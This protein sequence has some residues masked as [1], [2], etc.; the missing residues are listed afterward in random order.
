MSRRA[1]GLLAVALLSG[2]AWAQQRAIDTTTYRQELGRIRAALD[3][4]DLEG[5]KTRAA[6]LRG[7]VVAD[8]SLRYESDGSLLG[9]LRRAADA[10]AASALRPRLE[11][12]I[13]SLDQPPPAA[14]P[15]ADHDLLESLR[16]AESPEALEKG[17]QVGL[18]PLRALTLRDSVVQMLDSVARAIDEQLRR[19]W[20]FLNKLG[21]KRSA[22]AGGGLDARPA[23][24][25]IVIVAAA[26]LLLL[27]V[28]VWRRRGEASLEVSAAA[29]AAESAR[30]A[31]P[32]SREANEWEDHARELEAAGRRREAIRAWYHA[33][34]VTLFRQG[35]LHY[36]KGRTNWE[37]A[38]ALPPEA[39]WRPAFFAITRRFDQEWYGRASSD[40]DVLRD[41]SS[42]AQRILATLR[43]AAA[44]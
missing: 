24:V 28:R 39:G 12:L 8:G 26:T 41:Y 22:K 40:P 6:A 5:A 42:E 11:A 43:R 23:T 9:P 1:G 13:R 31:D 35:L 10:R 33:V 29:G 21:P 36:E 18:G 19:F 4:A 44:A 20:R 3:A 25:L 7:L 30:D 17:G 27:A 15:A 32:L 16:R 37:Y 38:A 14:A 2:P 34:L